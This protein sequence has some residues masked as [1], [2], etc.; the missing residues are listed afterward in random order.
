MR[1]KPTFM[2]LAVLTALAGSQ[3][4]AAWQWSDVADR[5]GFC[6]LAT[7]Y[8][9]MAI[10]SSGVKAFYGPVFSGAEVDDSGLQ[11]FNSSILE[12]GK[13]M[14][15]RVGVEKLRIQPFPKNGWYAEAHEEIEPYTPFMVFCFRRHEQSKKAAESLRSKE[16]QEDSEDGRRV[17]VVDW[18]LPP[19]KQQQAAP[20]QQQAST[21]ASYGALAIDA[22]QGNRWGAAWAYTTQGGAEQR[23][24]QECGAGCGVVLRFNN[25]CAAY[26]A[27]Q[28][29]GSTAYGWGVKPTRSEAESL[30]LNECR[31]RGGGNDQCSIRVWGCAMDGDEREPV[32]RSGTLQPSSVPGFYGALA[33]DAN[34]GD[35]WGYSFEQPSAAAA[36]VVA[37]SKCGQGCRIV[38]RF[39]NTCAAFAADQQTG[40]TAYGH[41]HGPSKSSAVDNAMRFCREHGGSNA[42]CELRVWACSLAN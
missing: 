38:R 7:S 35:Q 23:A 18:L 29:S 40:S 42:N 4:A 24:V 22:N 41:G 17:V 11:D 20:Q 30:A 39:N 2:L 15:Q 32:G 25:A 9:G 12:W 34:Q 14:F 1:I 37:L 10:G 31:K 16:I 28:Q 26:A 13:L 5:W 8:Y 36:E 33:V 21:G 3:Q 6:R 19:M 27:D